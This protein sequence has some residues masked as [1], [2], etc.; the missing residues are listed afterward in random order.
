MLL[1]QR[2]ITC[3]KLCV[4]YTCKFGVISI[5]YVIIIFYFF[6]ILFIIMEKLNDCGQWG[7]CGGLCFSFFFFIYKNVLPFSNCKIKTTLIPD[8]CIIY[9]NIKHHQYSIV[10]QNDLSQLAWVMKFG[11]EKCYTLSVNRSHSY[12]KYDKT[13]KGQSL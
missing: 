12:T 2:Q 6:K 8:V 1:P 13:L 7:V 11:P 4:Y 3:R 9:W 10:L 5:K